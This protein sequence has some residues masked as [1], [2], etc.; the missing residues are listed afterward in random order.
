MADPTVIT[1]PPPISEPSR[2]VYLAALIALV[3]AFALGLVLG[4]SSPAVP[5]MYSKPIGKTWVVTGLSQSEVITVRS[6]L[7]NVTSADMGSTSNEDA[8]SFE[9]N[10]ND[11]DGSVSG[12]DSEA[13]HDDTGSQNNAALKHGYWVDKY[14]VSKADVVTQG[15]ISSIVTVGALAGSL[16]ASYGTTLFGKRNA[17]AY[18]GVPFTASW[19][20]IY[21]APNVSVLMAGRFLTGFFS[22]IISGTA[23]SYVCEI[24]TP[25]TRGF[26]GSG[27][28]VNLN[29]CH[30][31]NLGN[32][33]KMSEYSAVRRR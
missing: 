27:F 7:P 10:Y 5:Q 11:L 30:S 19:L 32:A 8:G 17:L 21:F 16:L 2:I 12:D 31:K 15:W 26:L 33:M 20:L 24:A 1:R 3:G 18:Y 28:Q 13:D 9:S 6:P 22:G 25:S 29:T 4:Y 14:F 23:P